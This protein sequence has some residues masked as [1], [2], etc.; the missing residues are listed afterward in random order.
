MNCQ[1]CQSGRHRHVA[2]VWC[3][4]YIT[5]TFRDDVG[6]FAP[7]TGIER[8]LIEDICSCTLSDEIDDLVDW[9]LSEAPAAR[10]HQLRTGRFATAGLA[11][12]PTTQ[13]EG[14]D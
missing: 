3:G 8:T 9:Q 14:T 7:P 6:I 2:Q 13:P 4:A 5:R 1:D 12:P 11:L 10:Q